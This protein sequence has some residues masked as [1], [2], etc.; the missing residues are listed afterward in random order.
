[1]SINLDQFDSANAP[2]QSSLP[3]AKG[4]FYFF[5]AS[6]GALVVVAIIL[7][8]MFVIGQGRNVA[9]TSNPPTASA[10][11][12]QA[13][14]QTIPPESKPDPAASPLDGEQMN[15]AVTTS[16]CSDPMADAV[17]IFDFVLAATSSQ[18][19]DETAQKLVTDALATLDR[20]CR[21]HI[22]HL[23]AVQHAL[24]DPQAPPQI[25]ALVKDASWITRQR[26]VP[27]GAQTP[28]GRFTTGLE[29]I[30]CSIESD[31]VAC[32]INNYSWQAPSGCSGQPATVRIDPAMNEP[33][34]TCL[35]RVDAET[36]YDYGT[37]LAN[38]GYVCTVESSGITCWSEFTGHGFAL[39]RENLRK[40]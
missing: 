22:P 36:Q 17:P 26:P 37:V 2:E 13:E 1:M 7:L 32:T 3:I 34:S 14:P 9:E 40:F 35:S 28:T 38:H 15:N 18:Q 27:Q 31:G 5:L 25:N 23:L 11:S 33:L 12:Q 16:S 29:N 20:T 19:W 8:F 10:P 6:L 24:V 30:H 4:P 21:D 39:S